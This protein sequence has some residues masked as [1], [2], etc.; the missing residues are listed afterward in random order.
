MTKGEFLEKLADALQ[1]EE[2][3]LPDFKLSDT[4]YWDSVSQM[5]MLAFFHKHFGVH[6]S[7]EEL[8]MVENVGDLLD[9][10]RAYLSD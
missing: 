3:P 8:N 1:M 10:A 7:I 6:V 2:V 5:S 4:D 9:I